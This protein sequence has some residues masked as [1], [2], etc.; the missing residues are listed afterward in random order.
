VYVLKFESKCVGYFA[1]SGNDRKLR[2]GT[3]LSLTRDEADDKI[4]NCCRSLHFYAIDT[5]L[6]GLLCI[7]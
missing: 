2:I 4:G 5:G 7:L 1:V 3:E 6:Q